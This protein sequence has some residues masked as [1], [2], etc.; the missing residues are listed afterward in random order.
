LPQKPGTMGEATEED[1]KS[2]GVVDLK[3]DPLPE[4]KVYVLQRQDGLAGQKTPW[5]YGVDEN[6]VV[7]IYS[8]R[9]MAEHARAAIKEDR[10]EIEEMQLDPP[11]KDSASPEASQNEGGISE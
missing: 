5:W 9:Q 6:E 1:E 2:L 10:C 8:S 7:G 4:K 11:N 3:R